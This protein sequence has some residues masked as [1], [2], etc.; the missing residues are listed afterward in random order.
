MS[1]LLA[2]I[3]VIECATLRNGDNVGMLLGDL[4]ADVIK[5]ESPR[6][7]D[8]L[9]IISGEITPQNSR[10]HVQFNRNKRSVTIDLRNP[11]GRE[12][13]WRLLD[14]ADVFVDGYVAGACD[15]LGIGYEE[16]RRRRPGIVYAQHSGFG[17]MSPYAAIPTHGQMM[18]ALAGRFPVQAGYDGLL[19]R[20][21]PGPS[22]TGTR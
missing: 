21:P 12:V 6:R 20:V 15:R 9:R 18:D 13:F 16:Q 8:H 5:V 4:G 17:A 1:K 14:T 10:A 7:G 2:D 22:L 3:R 19:H 11:A